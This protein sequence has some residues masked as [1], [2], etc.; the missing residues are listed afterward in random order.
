M[1]DFAMDFSTVCMILA[2]LI[3]TLNGM[4]VVCGANVVKNVA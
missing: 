3:F 1:L 2:L 4:Q